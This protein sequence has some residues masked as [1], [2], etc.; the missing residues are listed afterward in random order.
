[1]YTKP[2]AAK[3]HQ[4]PPQDLSISPL[5]NNHQ[6]RLSSPLQKMEC[7]AHYLPHV[8]RMPYINVVTPIRLTDAGH[9]IVNP[10]PFIYTEPESNH[11]EEY[12]RP[13]SPLRQNSSEDHP[14]RMKSDKEL[15]PRGSA[16]F[17]ARGRGRGYGNAK[18]KIYKRF[19]SY[20]MVSRP[21]Y[22]TEY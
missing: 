3:K 14:V 19:P 10:G 6:L 1:M 8:P 5:K 22:Y 21:L 15:V 9:F 2:D 12:H 4:M 20:P 11:R 17:Q 18:P 13:P 16:G 7:M